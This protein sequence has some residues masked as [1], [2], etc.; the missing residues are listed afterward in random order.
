MKDI[1]KIIAESVQNGG[2]DYVREA[3][4]RILGED[5]TSGQTVAV[6]DDPINGL[7]GSKAKVRSTSTANPGFVECELENGTMVNLQSSLLVPV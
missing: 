6:I 5:I 1:K 4:H 3:V 2:K 7:S